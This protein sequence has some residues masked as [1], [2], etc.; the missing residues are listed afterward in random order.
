MS[1]QLKDY[2]ILS[3]MR[4]RIKKEIITWNGKDINKLMDRILE[5]IVHAAKTE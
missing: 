4:E 3:I 1:K 5:H 2:L